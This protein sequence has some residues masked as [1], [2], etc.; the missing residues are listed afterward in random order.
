[1]ERLHDLAALMRAHPE[2]RTPDRLL[3]H[4]RA[5]VQSSGLTTTTDEAWRDPGS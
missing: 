3:T 5:I 2:Y 4:V 1:M